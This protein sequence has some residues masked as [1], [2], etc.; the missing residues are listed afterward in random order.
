MKWLILVMLLVSTSAFAEPSNMHRVPHCAP[1]I[2]NLPIYQ[3]TADDSHSSVVL[4]GKNTWATSSHSVKDGKAKKIKLYL[5]GPREVEAKIT[6]INVEKDIAV[7]QA[8]SRKIRPIDSMSFNL[9]DK[10]QVW[11]IG[12]AG[13]A[14]GELLSFTGFQVRYNKGGMLVVS[15][16]GLHG[17]SGGANIRCVNGKAELVG[18]ISSLV[19]HEIETKVWTDGAGILHSDRTLTNKGISII[20]PIRFDAAQ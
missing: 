11:N 20:S 1:V 4:V 9:A 10:E 17:M 15:A 14:A 3:I 18:I 6:F 8:D 5:P 13:I 19:N 2:R 12:Y 7:L 16:L